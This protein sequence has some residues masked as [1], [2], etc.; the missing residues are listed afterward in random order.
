MDTM[1]GDRPCS[2]LNNLF[3]KRIKATVVRAKIPYIVF[4]LWNVLKRPLIKR[5]QNIKACFEDTSRR[6]QQ[7][8]RNSELFDTLQW[9]I[10][11]QGCSLFKNMFLLLRIVTNEE[12]EGGLPQIWKFI[13]GRKISLLGFF[14]VIFCPSRTN[15]EIW[16]EKEECKLKKR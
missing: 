12:K 5:K 13:L 7:W 8:F 9:R 15:T 11:S 1:K 2:K 6:K 4:V 10:D 14:W 16:L 3:L